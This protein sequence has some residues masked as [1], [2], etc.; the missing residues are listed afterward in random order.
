MNEAKIPC[1]TR[2]R[3]VLP[4]FP[5][6]RRLL[7]IA[8][9][10]AVAPALACR[11]VS[12][13][14]ELTAL[15]EKPI[16]DFDPR[17]SSDSA[18]ERM[19]QLMFN[20]LT[21]KDEK[22]DPAPDLA[23]RFEPSSDYKTFTF[24]LR[25]NIKFHN[26][27]KLSAADVRYTFA[28]MMA[29]GFK[30]AKRAEL[31]RDRVSVEVD[32][33]DPQKVMFHCGVPC[34]GLPITILPIGIIPEGTSE[35]Q[36]KQPIGTG[37][38]KFSSYTEDQEVVLTAF[39]EYY[40]GRSNI[41]RL[42]VK[43]IPDNSA[44]E[45]ELRKGSVDLA[46]NADFDPVTVEGLQKAERLK[47]EIIEGTNITHLGINLQD[48]ILKDQRVRQALAYSVD[49]EA[50]IRDI[51]RGQ[52]RVA[53]SILPPGQWAFE[54]AGAIY[55]YDPERAKKLLDEAG[56]TERDGQRRMKL[57]LKTSTLS[58]ARK[59]GEA[60]QEQ[61]RRVGIELELQPLE[62][63]TLTQDWSDGN[64]QLYLNTLVGGNQFTNIFKFVYS[65]K[66]IP[67]NGQNRSR[68]SNLQVDKLLDEAQLASR[69]QGREIFSQIQKTL[70]DELPQIY[71]WHPA[72]IVVYQDRVS[73][74][75]IEPSGDWRV[76]R[77]MKVKA[78]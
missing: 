12:R 3:L 58:I 62:R 35:Q 66:S 6:A 16:A 7:L 72:T 73:D 68:Y 18:V 26:G 77:N 71:L 78:Q 24:Y 23:E 4:Y 45:S 30:S 15:L 57:S 14:N 55:K 70:A 44:R 46:I 53:Q 28:T 52:A 36:S 63:E 29:K 40:E 43:I 27:Q 65:S 74:V 1:G 25:P 51:L 41:N 67:P 11:S 56:K 59:T 8:V 2:W 13:E 47:V 50:I 64:F 60:L 37:P 9:I 48:P 38:F 33:S 22:F 61:M 34:P 19:R 39:D 5:A 21:R 42:R 31:E 10:L 54:P 32:P 76:I 69:E 17:T 49:R 20:G 75:K